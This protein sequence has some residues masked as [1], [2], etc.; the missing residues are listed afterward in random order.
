MT[1]INISEAREEL[2][3]VINRVAYGK[4]RVIV[5]RRGK[6]LA[7]VLPMEDLR[8]PERLEQE[9][10]DRRDLAAARLASKDAKRKGT[11]SLQRFLR[12][13]GN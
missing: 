3:E 6:D 2:P 11:K 4:E 8:M 10:R 9:E 12:E 7:A 13:T 1:K 5:E